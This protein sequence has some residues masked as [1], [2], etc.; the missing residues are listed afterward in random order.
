[1]KKKP[2]LG[3]KLVEQLALPFIRISRQPEQSG[4][5]WV[6]I[7][8]VLLAV[9][10]AGALVYLPPFVSTNLRAILWLISINSALSLLALVLTRNLTSQSHNL[11]CTTNFSPT[12]KILLGGPLRYI[13]TILGISSRLSFQNPNNK[14][15]NIRL[16]W[17]H[18]KLLHCNHLKL[19][20]K[21]QSSSLCVSDF[22]STYCM[23]ATCQ[24]A[25]HAKLSQSFVKNTK[26]SLL[27]D[28]KII[29]IN[30]QS[31]MSVVVTAHPWHLNSNNPKST[32]AAASEK[33]KKDCLC[34][35]NSFYR[36]R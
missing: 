22:S 13:Q 23:S 32:N 6:L 3:V 30:K 14:I 20:M 33:G 9:G 7:D 28:L 1:M 24:T 27:Y 29:R 18:T 31:W 15:V 2:N 4:P 34:Q 21:A 16:A 8:V 12:I 26:V 5:S 11:S 10:G 19:Q 25:F 35:Q 17:P 36:H